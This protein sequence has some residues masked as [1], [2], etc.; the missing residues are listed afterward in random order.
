MAI[1]PNEE[2]SPEQDVGNLIHE[3]PI[4]L[5]LAHIYR[6][7]SKTK[8]DYYRVQFFRQERDAEKKWLAMSFFRE[9]LVNIAKTATASEDWLAFQL[10]V[11]NTM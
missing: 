3:I 6:N 11:A 4:G 10:K 2:K 9:D 1:Q 7:V 5:V 8:G